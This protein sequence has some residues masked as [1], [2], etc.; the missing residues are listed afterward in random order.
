MDNCLHILTV[1]NQK[2]VRATGVKEVTFFN[3][4]EIRLKLCCGATLK[5]LGEG[6]KI[7][8]FDDKN[9]TFNALGKVFGTSYKTTENILKKVLK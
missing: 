7:T 5:I 1:E 6:L 9:G 3:D 2:S 4:R 8:G